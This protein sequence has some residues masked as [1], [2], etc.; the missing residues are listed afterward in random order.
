MTRR[1]NGDGSPLSLFSFQD[2]ITGVTG[3]MIFILLLLAIN[4][5]E[6]VVSATPK[7]PVN[8]KRQR[9]LEEYNEV[10]DRLKTVR[11]SYLKV[12]N[13]LAVF[14]R[15]DRD[16]L[17]QQIADSELALATRKLEAKAL[18]DKI[19]QLQAKL[20]GETAQTK[21]WLMQIIELKKRY[22]ELKEKLE[23]QQ[24]FNRVEFI[25]SNDAEGKQPIFVQLSDRKIAVKT[26]GGN[27]QVYFWPNDDK[28]FNKFKQ[29]AETRDNKLEYFCFLIKPSATKII[30]RRP[31]LCLTKQPFVARIK[32]Q[33]EVGLEPLAE[34]KNAV[35]ESND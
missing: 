1:G 3:I 21:A 2:I 24:D 30:Y 15:Y 17:Q 14:R 8:K 33:F 19:K 29:F 13:E 28:G 16:K 6:K 27:S 23:K 10:T 12:K 20:P 22:E 5:P 32:K 11:I 7:K 34:E 4:I 31:F 26:F 35:Y 9:M 18:H 25:P